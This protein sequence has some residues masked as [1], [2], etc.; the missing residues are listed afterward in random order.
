MQD[1][2]KCIVAQLTN[3]FC[4]FKKLYSSLLYS[5]EPTV[6]SFAELL[7]SSVHHHTLFSAH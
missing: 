7:G 3:K 6:Y 4:A 2:Q 5:Q 1:L